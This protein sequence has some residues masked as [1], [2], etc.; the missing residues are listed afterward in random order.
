MQGVGCKN[1]V[2]RRR[3]LSWDSLLAF[4]ED[5]LEWLVPISKRKGGRGQARC[6]P[7]H[8]T[9]CP[10]AYLLVSLSACLPVQGK[11]GDGAGVR[12]GGCKER[13]GD[14]IGGTEEVL[15]GNLAHE[16]QPLRRT[17]QQAHAQGHVVVPGGGGVLMNEVPLCL[18]GGAEV[19]LPHQWRWRCYLI[20]HNVLIKWFL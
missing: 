8:P 3:I 17:L 14:L 19:V 6:L 12:G 18:V 7:T 16:K 20:S 11:Q 1:F 10:T 5:L 15:Q 4:S 9:V 2:Y 13:V